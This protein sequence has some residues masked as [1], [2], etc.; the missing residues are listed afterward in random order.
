MMLGWSLTYLALCLVAGVFGFGGY[1]NA[2]EGFAQV[3][4]FMFLVGHLVC[5]ALHLI[6]PRKRGHNIP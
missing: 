6:G 1:P 2:E 5:L 4:F 3:L